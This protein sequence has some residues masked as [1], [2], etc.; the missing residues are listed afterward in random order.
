MHVKKYALREE[1]SSV[2]TVGSGLVLHNYSILTQVT[3]T[4]LGGHQ[5]WALVATRPGTVVATC[6]QLRYPP[7]GMSP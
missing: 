3:H 7:A 4:I 2:V 5:T 6:L 1:T